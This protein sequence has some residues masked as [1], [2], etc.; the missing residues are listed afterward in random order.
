MAERNKAARANEDAVAITQQNDPSAPVVRHLQRQLANAAILYFNYK[1]FHWQTYGPLFRDL[2]LVFDEFADE[3]LETLDPIAERLRMIGQD[4]VAGPTEMVATASV[5]PAALAQTMREMV[6]GA[7]D[8]LLTVIR[9]MRDAVR[10]AEDADDPGTVDLFS[11][12]VQIHEKHEW[13]LRELLE[14]GDRLVS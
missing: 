2:H 8:Q 1:R 5:K 11:R 12:Y 7:D 6:A 3:V 14:R 9:E 13:W 10:A 4:P